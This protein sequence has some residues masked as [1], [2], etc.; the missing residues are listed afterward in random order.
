MFQFRI[1]WMNMFAQNNNSLPN[2]RR[3]S[4]DFVDVLHEISWL[5][6]MC[7]CFWS[8][9]HNE[10]EGRCIWNIQGAGLVGS[11]NISGSASCMSAQSRSP[12]AEAERTPSKFRADPKRTQSGP[13][14]DANFWKA[15]PKRTL[16]P[17]SGS[18]LM[19][20]LVRSVLAVLGQS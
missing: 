8:L 16:S 19:L 11:Y 2:T 6:Y 3:N 20:G 14:A 5:S 18:A 4:G 12:R 13:K 17:L 7:V 10:L 15:D 1:L 9:L